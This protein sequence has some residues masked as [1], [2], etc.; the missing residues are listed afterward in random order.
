MTESPSNANPPKTDAELATG[1]ESADAS[2]AGP[3]DQPHP[4]AE[5]SPYLA[6]D[7]KTVHPDDAAA[8]SDNPTSDEVSE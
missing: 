6:A 5:Q 7:E 1:P 8:G 4:T 2:A 3:D